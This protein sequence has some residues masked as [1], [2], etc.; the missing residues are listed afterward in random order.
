MAELPE[1][2]HPALP[3]PEDQ[4]KPTH[5]SSYHSKHIWTN[6]QSSGEASYA[7]PTHYLDAREEAQCVD[8][9]TAPLCYC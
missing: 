4:T 9:K 1:S 7:S 5:F 8:Q 2:H 6:A 3:M